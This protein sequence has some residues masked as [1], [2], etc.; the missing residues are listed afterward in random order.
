MPACQQTQPDPPPGWLD[1]P[2]P[3][4]RG[5]SPV[6][7]GPQDL[8]KR[9]RSRTHPWVWTPGLPHGRQPLWGPQNLPKC[10]SFGV[11]SLAV[12]PEVVL[13]SGFPWLSSTSAPRDPTT[14]ILKAYSRLG[15]VVFPV[16]SSI[17]NEKRPLGSSF[18]P[19]LFCGFRFCLV[20]KGLPHPEMRKWNI[21]PWVL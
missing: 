15:G 14:M 2:C 17:L 8:K 13:S 11:P 5:G 20:Q 12:L 10:Q 18:V 21:L 9:G 6:Q 16:T 3:V 7:G 1:T 4:P 19:H